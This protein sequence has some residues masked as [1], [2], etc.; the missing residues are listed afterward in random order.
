MS[1]V[2]MLINARYHYAAKTYTEEIDPRLS[3]PEPKK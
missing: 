2:A 1:E 3:I